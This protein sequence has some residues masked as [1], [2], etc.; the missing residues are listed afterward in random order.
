VASSRFKIRHVKSLKYNERG[1]RIEEMNTLK[2][3]RRRRRS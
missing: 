1:G 3:R 2:S